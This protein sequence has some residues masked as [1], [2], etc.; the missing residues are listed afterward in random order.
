MTDSLKRWFDSAA[1]TD[2]PLEA[3]L[4]AIARA[5][6]LATDARNRSG[7]ER[8]DELVEQVSRGQI[9]PRAAATLAYYRANIW[10][11]IHTLKSPDAPG[12]WDWQGEETQQEILYLRQAAYHP[13]FEDIDPVRKCQIDTNLG[14]LLNRVGRAVDAIESWNRAL[15]RIPR[16]AMARGNRGHGLSYYS[17]ALY[18]R[19]HMAMMMLAAHDDLSATLA[20]CRT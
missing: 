20:A 7:L 2:Q 6:D 5:I 15:A 18:D 14:N 13:G 9:S 8:A 11:A 1:D 12:I 16:F 10:S 4:D 3:R 17:R 19:S